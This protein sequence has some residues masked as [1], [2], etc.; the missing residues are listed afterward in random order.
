MNLAILLHQ[1]GSLVSLRIPFWAF[2][3]IM[4]ILAIVEALDFTSI[5]RRLVVLVVLIVSSILIG[6]PTVIP[7]F[8]A[9]LYIMTNLMTLEAFDLV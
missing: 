2:V 1:Q 8:R 6:V 5:Y 9:I 7:I 3:G 4:S